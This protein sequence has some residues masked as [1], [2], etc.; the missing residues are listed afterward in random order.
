MVV[1]MPSFFCAKSASDAVAACES[2]TDSAEHVAVVDCSQL[3]YVD[4]FGIAML[5]ATFHLVQLQG[6]QIQVLNLSANLQGYLTRMDVFKDV[7]L[8]GDYPV[9]VG[10][11][12]DRSTEL[13]ELTCLDDKNQVDDAAFR[14]AKT[15]VGQ[16]DG[17]DPNEPPDE[18]SCMNT[19]DRLAEP[20]QYAL[21]ELLENALT[22]ARRGGYPS[23]K[24]W[25]AS[26]YYRRSGAIHLG[27][28]DDGCGFLRSLEAHPSLK[29]KRD[30]EAILLALQPRVSCNR[31]QWL[32]QPDSVNQGVGLTT[33]ARMA[34]KSGGRM[35]IVSG[36]AMHD[37]S[38]RTGGLSSGAYWQGVAIALE[39]QRKRLPEVR[40]RELLPPYDAKPPV[41]L[42]FE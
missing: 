32:N 7:K 5:G 13:V 27:V 28:V 15:I 41:A 10:T 20:I 31:D 4:P 39:C 24:V 19:A 40:I 9:A 16:L 37:T 26:Q 38:G 25:V 42:R 30:H 12:H 29:H 17:I 33:T 22:H 36:S 23:S 34:Q 6:R 11:R 35:V 8:V 18:M 1:L 2:I 14:L 3:K 21:S